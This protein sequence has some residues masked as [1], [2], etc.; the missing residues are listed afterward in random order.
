MLLLVVVCNVIIGLSTQPCDLI[1]ASVTMIIKMV[2]ATSLTSGAQTY[3]PHQQHLLD[4]LPKSL[5]AALNT[6]KLD[7]KTTV[8]AAC[9]SCHFTH[10]PKEHRITHERVY[11]AICDNYIVGTESQCSEPLLED[12]NGKLRPIK[13][14][15]YVSFVDHLARLLADPEVEAMC[16]QACDEVLASIGEPAPECVNNVFEAQFLRT[17]QGPESNKLFVDR[18]DKVRLALR[19]S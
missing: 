13:P 11:P 19:S 6:F 16:D 15:L 12:R 14:F 3:D 10:A 18:G 5:R 1:I 7:A 2:M 8:Y 4:Q 17:F 9:P